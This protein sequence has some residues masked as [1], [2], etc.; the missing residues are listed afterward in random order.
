MEKC[1]N[2]NCFY[3]ARYEHK[4]IAIRLCEDCGMKFNKLRNFQHI[5]EVSLR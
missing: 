1:M 4:G 5:Q 2:I 3:N